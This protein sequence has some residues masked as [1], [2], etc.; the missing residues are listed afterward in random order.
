MIS[1]DA[2]KQLVLAARKAVESHLNSQELE[3]SE[4]TKQLL[5][6]KRGIVVS[7]KKK[8]ELRGF[9]ADREPS[10]NMLDTV[11]ITAKGAAFDNPDFI[12]MTKEE[13]NNVKF[14]IGVL[15]E[16]E[17]LPETAEERLESIELGKDGLI[18]RMGPT[19]GYLLPHTAAEYKWTKEEFFEN[20]CAKAGLS[21]DMWTDENVEFSK[22]QM[23]V[24]RE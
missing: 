12:D 16:P 10:Y 4:A 22:F 13:I 15:S 24:F 20:A 2:G 11:V 19:S 18:A 8:G 23:Q 7:I 6:D 1:Q 17:I 5:A 3:F 14:E 21:P 9:M